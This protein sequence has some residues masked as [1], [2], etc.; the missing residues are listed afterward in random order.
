MKIIYNILKLA[1]CL[2]MSALICVVEFKYGRFLAE[3]FIF[4]VFCFLLIL[5]FDKISIINFWWLKVKLHKKIKEADDILLKMKILAEVM[6]EAIINS[7]ASEQLPIATTMHI[8]YAHELIEKIRSVTNT[9][10]INRDDGIWKYI[11][12]NKYF[13]H[14]IGNFQELSQ[15][16]KQ[17]CSKL[18]SIKDCALFMI[19]AKSFLLK[20]IS[21]YDKNIFK[22]FCYYGKTGKHL[23][24]KKFEDILSS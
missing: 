13:R 19:E 12:L 6:G 16:A 11:C 10:G 20:N 23:D 8:L 15:E 9:F 17:E 24:L 18:F 3:F 7:I 14:L 1:F 2:L 22:L 21:N 5:N 4:S